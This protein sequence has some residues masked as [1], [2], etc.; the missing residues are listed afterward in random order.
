MANLDRREGSSSNFRERLN[1]TAIP[2]T[3]M[4]RRNLL[5]AVNIAMTA[6]IPRIPSIAS[7]LIV[8]NYNLSFHT[9]ITTIRI[10]KSLNEVYSPEIS[11]ESHAGEI[12]LSIAKTL[13]TLLY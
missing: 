5:F 10:K 9:K 3:G 13:G 4:H 12:C 6:K 7:S 11:I 1:N 8:D 2:K